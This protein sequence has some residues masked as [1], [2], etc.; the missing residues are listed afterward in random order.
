MNMDLTLTVSD[1]FIQKVFF[2]IIP[3]FSDHE[4]NS[5]EGDRIMHIVSGRQFLGSVNYNSKISYNLLTEKIRMLGNIPSKIIGSDI[6]DNAAD[7]KEILKGKKSDSD[8]DKVLLEKTDVLELNWQGD[9]TA[10][11][12]RRN[13][14]I[15]FELKINKN[16]IDYDINKDKNNRENISDDYNRYNDVCEK[17][18]ENEEFICFDIEKDQTDVMTESTIKKKNEVNNYH[19]K[20]DGNSND[21]DSSS[22]RNY[23][24]DNYNHTDKNDINDDKNGDS[25]DDDN[26][27]I[28]A[29]RLIGSLQ[30]VKGKKTNRYTI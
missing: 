30:W 29:F 7:N 26:S 2:L 14:T 1:F 13:N 23:S 19:D 5:A 25:K 10:R 17:T 20:D 6:Y 8:S 18:N 9:V 24:N 3:K 27:T 16:D 12:V 21:D 4:E 15:Y 11:G 28:S 22:V